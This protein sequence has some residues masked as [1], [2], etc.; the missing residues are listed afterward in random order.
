MAQKDTASVIYRRYRRTRG[1]RVLD[2]W[3]YGHKAWP[4]RLRR[5]RR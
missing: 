5:R 1:G 3:K 4:I 2:A